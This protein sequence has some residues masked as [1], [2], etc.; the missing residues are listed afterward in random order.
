MMLKQRPMT[1]VKMSAQ[2][3]VE[4]QRHHTDFRGERGNRSFPVVFTMFLCLFKLGEF[5]KECIPF[6]TVFLPRWCLKM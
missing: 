5:L 3:C 4:V 6:T 1:L 2:K